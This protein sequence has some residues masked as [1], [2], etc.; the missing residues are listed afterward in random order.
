M[1]QPIY[2]LT[3]LDSAHS[4]YNAAICRQGREGHASGS[5]T[6]YSRKKK[7]DEIQGYA[8]YKLKWAFKQAQCAYDMA[9]GVECQSEFFMLGK[10]LN[11]LENTEE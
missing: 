2:S 1:A 7:N 4:I 6:A 9:I 11:P 5:E 10:R 3:V 8:C